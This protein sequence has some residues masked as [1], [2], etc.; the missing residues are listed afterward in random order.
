VAEAV[1]MSGHG[2]SV[3]RRLHEQQEAARKREQQ[4]KQLAWARGYGLTGDAST[5]KWTLANEDER[6]VFGSLDDVEAFL[7]TKPLQPKDGD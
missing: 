6:R 4:A 3:Q 5:D 2:D 1:A 7:S